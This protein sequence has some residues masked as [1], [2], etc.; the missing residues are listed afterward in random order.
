MAQPAKPTDFIYVPLH[1]DLYAELV[2]R[3]GSADVSGFIEHSVES[4]LDRTEGDAGIWSSEYIEKLAV[5][6]DDGFYEKY[7]DPNRGY[8]WQNV[9]LPNGTQVRMTYRGEATYGEIRNEKLYLDEVSMS[10]SEFAR[11]VANNTSRNAWRDI[12][13]KFPGDGGWKFADDLRRQRA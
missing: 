1:V 11:H 5:A 13:V 4:F 6:E 3:S 10:P 8:Q 12:Y 7:G 9:Y 2:N